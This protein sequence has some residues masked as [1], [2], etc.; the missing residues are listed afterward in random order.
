MNHKQLSKLALALGAMVMAGGAMAQSTAT[1]TA[2]VGA[3]ILKPIS[4]AKD[5]DLNFGKVVPGAALGTVVLS[6]LAARTPSGGTTIMATQTG[7]VAAAQFTVTGEGAATYT[8]SLPESTTMALTG[9]PGTTMTVDEFTSDLETVE[10]IATLTG[11]AGGSGT[12]VIKVGA[13]LNVGA[14][15]PQGVYSGTFEVTVAYN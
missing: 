9:T 5:V 7:T 10:G 13:T 12:K 8:L 1:G 2:N 11:T 6:P 3:T 15:Q 14:N 4:I